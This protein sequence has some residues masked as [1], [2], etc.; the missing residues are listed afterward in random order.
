[1]LLSWLGSVLAHLTSVSVWWLYLVRNLDG[2]NPEGVNHCHCF[3]KNLMK[4]LLTSFAMYSR[5]DTIYGT[6]HLCNSFSPFCRDVFRPSSFSITSNARQSPSTVFLFSNL[7]HRPFALMPV[8][9]PLD[10]ISSKLD[11]TC[12]YWDSTALIAFP[13]IVHLIGQSGL[14]DFTG[15]SE[16]TAAE[17]VFLSFPDCCLTSLAHAPTARN[18]LSKH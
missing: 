7:S 16:L 5:S 14:S 8:L 9:D 1:M 12:S 18:H 10:A 2:L 6:S 13:L 17:N 4:A 15:P 11:K 3:L